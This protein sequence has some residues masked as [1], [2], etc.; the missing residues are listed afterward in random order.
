MKPR[1]PR[2]PL[3]HGALALALGALAPGAAQAWGSLLLIDPP[4]QQ[5][6]F[7]AGPSIWRLPAY[8]GSKS[9]RTWLIPGL[10]YE[11]PSGFFASTDSGVGWNFAPRSGLQAGLRL[12][13]Q[14]GR[15]AVDA[16]PGIGGLGNRIALEGFANVELASVLLLQSGLQ[17]GGGPQHDATQFEIGLTSGLPIGGDLLGI[18]IATTWSSRNGAQAV[19]GISPA[20]AAASGLPAFAAPAGWQDRSLTLSFEHRLAAHWRIDAQWIAA[21][22]IGGAARSPLLQSASQSGATLTL[23]HEF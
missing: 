6:S 17:L 2:T 21:R 13:P 4:P 5:A 8:A 11:H 7:A 23:W 10:D 16:P 14:F 22:L 1:H 3:L 20:Q 18:G 12:W 15:S 9:S 19:F